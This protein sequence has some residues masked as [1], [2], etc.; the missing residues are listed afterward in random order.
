[1]LIFDSTEYALGAF[2]VS[3]DLTEYALVPCHAWKEG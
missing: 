1:M 3:V 2:M